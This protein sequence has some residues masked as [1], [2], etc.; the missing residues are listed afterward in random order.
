MKIKSVSPPF[1]PDI[2]QIILENQSRLANGAEFVPAILRKVA[3]KYQNLLLQNVLF[4]GKLQDLT[5]IVHPC[6][7][8]ARG[9][10]TS[11]EYYTEYKRGRLH[12]I[13]DM[14]VNI[15]DSPKFIAFVF[16]HEISHMLVC[17]R[18]YL[19]SISDHSKAGCKP[20]PSCINRYLPSEPGFFGEGLEE[21]IADNL[22]MYVVSRCR[23]SDEMGTYAQ[24]THEFS[25]RQVSTGFCAFV[26]CG[27]WRPF[28]GM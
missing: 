18:R 25:C 4:I 9:N 21:S 12:A 2:P 26:G 11:G 15:S 7:D 6:G 23:C 10:H 19:W 14:Y 5:V 22:A 13:V 27:L 8:D 28:G 1:P 24:F 16:A 20:G 17:A 3:R